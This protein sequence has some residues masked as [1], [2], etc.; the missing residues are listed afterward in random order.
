MAG[1]AHVLLIIMFVCALF[2]DFFLLSVSL[3]IH[4]LLFQCFHQSQCMFCASVQSL[5][6]ICRLFS[7]HGLFSSPLAQKVLLCED[8]S[9]SSVR[10][11]YPKSWDISRTRTESRCM[12]NLRSREA[13][14]IL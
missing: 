2:I 11:N 8:L 9:A 6:G 4:L 13:H 1:R 14:I 7:V 10:S 12:S 3:L 5:D